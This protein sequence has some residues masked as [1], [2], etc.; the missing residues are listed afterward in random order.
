MKEYKLKKVIPDNQANQLSGKFL[1]AAHAQ[2]VI[3][4]DADGY[5]LAGNLLF[6]FRKNVLDKDKMLRAVEDAQLEGRISTAGE[7]MDLVAQTWPQ[8]STGAP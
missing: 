2:I 7:A 5:D 6:R 8:A 3:D 1:T 4:H